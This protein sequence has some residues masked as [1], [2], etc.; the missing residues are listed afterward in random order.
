MQPVIFR[1]CGWFLKVYFLGV[2]KSHLK[3]NCQVHVI[4][5]RVTKSN[6]AINAADFKTRQ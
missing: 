3:R 2:S 4:L 6:I 5:L 1:S